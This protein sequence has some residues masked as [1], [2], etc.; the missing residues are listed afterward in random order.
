MREQLNGGGVQIGKEEIKI[1]Q[2]FYQTTVYLINIFSKVT[3]NKID[4]QKATDFLHTNEKYPGKEDT[5]EPFS[6]INSKT[7]VG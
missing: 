1:P 5:T 4:V 6:F 2:G 7:I 3:D